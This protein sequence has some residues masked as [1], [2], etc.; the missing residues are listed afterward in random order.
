MK[1]IHINATKYVQDL[2]TEIQK[3]FREILKSPIS[4]GFNRE[5]EQNISDLLEEIGLAIMTK[6]AQNP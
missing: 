5:T 6:Q 3:I 4:Q 2:Y 1:Y